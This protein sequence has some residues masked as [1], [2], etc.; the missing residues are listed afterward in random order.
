MALKDFFNHDEPPTNDDD[1]FI[2]ALLSYTSTDGSITGNSALKNSSVYSAINLISSKLANVSLSS[3]DDKLKKTLNDCHLR[4]SLIASAL[5]YGDS[6]AYLDNGKLQFL[7]NNNVTVTVNENGLDSKLTYTYTDGDNRQFQLDSKKVL[8]L[9]FF[10]TDGLTGISPL[11]SL[12]QEIQLAKSSNNL[13]LGFFNSPSRNVL[14][15]HK[16]NLSDEARSN[17]RA[18]FDNLNNSKLKTL[19][20]D[21]SA[22]YT[23]HT[24]DTSALQLSSSVDWSTRQIAA[25]FGIPPTYL[26]K[27]SEHSNS[28]QDE[29]QLQQTLDQYLKLYLMQLTNFFGT[30]V[31]YDEF[32]NLD[33]QQRISLVNQLSA[34]FDHDEALKL[35]GLAKESE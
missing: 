30:E 8:H 29:E 4:Q 1:A 25:A 22:D 16:T 21:D 12:S 27:E 28:S 14:K 6:F 11:Y 18:Q 5:L 35:L 32:K 2:Q 9:Y 24:M 15:I 33:L 31:S 20:L 17:L 19:V 7:P 34:Y 10:S 3:A 13:S 26:G 23:T